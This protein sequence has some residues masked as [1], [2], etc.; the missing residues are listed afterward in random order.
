MELVQDFWRAEE[1]SVDKKSYS[2]DEQACENLYQKTTRQ[3]EASRYIVSLPWKNRENL[4]SAH[5]ENSHSAAL[6]ALS[7]LEANFAKDEKLKIAYTEFIKEYIDLGHMSLSSNFD[8]FSTKS[9]AFLPHHGVWKETSTTTK[10]RSVFNGLS[11]YK[12]GVSANDLLHIGPDLLHIGPNLLQNPVTLNC[13]WRRYM[14]AL[15]A[16]VEKM[17]RQVGVEQF[18]QPYQSILWRFDKSEPIQIYRLTTVT[19]GLACSPF[20]AIWQ[21][22]SDRS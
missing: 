13:A 20:L 19:Y 10:L 3:D 7:G 12:S 16:D 8:S 6:R 14:I 18:D 21:N 9:E 17:F 11:K 4:R 15:S 2:P 22:V 1:I 5:F